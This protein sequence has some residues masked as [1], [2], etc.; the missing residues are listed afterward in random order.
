M[1][2]CVRNG[3][4]RRI[5]HRQKTYRLDIVGQTIRLLNL[6]GIKQQYS[7]RAKPQVLSL[8]H[9]VRTNDRSVHFTAVIA[10]NKGTVPASL[11]IRADQEHK[12]C[13]VGAF[14]DTS[15]LP[16]GLVT[17]QHIYLLRLIIHRSRSDHCCLQYLLYFFVLYLPVG[18]GA[19]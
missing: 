13:I 19:H 7:H 12:G 1:P 15:D 11:R 17:F 8:K 9:H 3:I 14:G 18:I 6:I 2:R 4:V 10:F 16:Q 5:A